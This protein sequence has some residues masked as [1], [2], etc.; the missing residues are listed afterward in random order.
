MQT[1]HKVASLVCSCLECLK[2]NLEL[3]VGWMLQVLMC[4]VAPDH[5]LTMHDVTNIWQA[6][7][8]SERKIV[9]CAAC[10]HGIQIL[11]MSIA[12]RSKPCTV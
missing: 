3:S 10:V 5:V 11:I 1:V 9:S 7:H 2:L 8:S 12:V 6:L 4:Q